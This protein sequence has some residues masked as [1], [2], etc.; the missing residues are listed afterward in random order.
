MKSKKQRTYCLSCLERLGILNTDKT[1]QF[2][3]DKGTFPR[4]V[5]RQRRDAKQIDQWY[6][7][8]TRVR[9]PKIKCKC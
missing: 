2:L 1:L 6:W 5:G 8:A 4:R 9:P 7:F 3:E